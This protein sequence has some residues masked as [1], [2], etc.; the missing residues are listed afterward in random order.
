LRISRDPSINAE[1]ERITR[2]VHPLVDWY[3][4]SLQDERQASYCS[5]S[6]CFLCTRLK[7]QQECEVLHGRLRIMQNAR[8]RSH[9]LN[10]HLTLKDCDS[11]TVR[12]QVH[13]LQK[14]W[15]RLSKHPVFRFCEGWYRAI[16]VKA[17]LSV[18]ENVHCHCILVMKPSYVS[19]NYLSQR[20][21]AELWRRCSASQYRSLDISPIRTPEQADKVAHYTLKHDFYTWADISEEA[22]LDPRRMLERAEQLKGLQLWDGSGVLAR[23][24]SSRGMREHFKASVARLNSLL[25]EPELITID[26]G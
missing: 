24:R 20:K 5:S 11:S 23:S 21:W 4:T 16:E 15:L 18:G 14:S 10:L 9:F 6:L 25:P 3:D 26:Q 7:A 19:R 1:A 12:E 13:H 2:C 22:I 8:P 17:G